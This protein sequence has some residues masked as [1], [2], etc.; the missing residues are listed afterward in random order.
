MIAYVAGI[1]LT[2]PPAPVT[3]ITWQ[4]DSGERLPYITVEHNGTQYVV[5]HVY[6]SRDLAEWAAVV[7]TTVQ[8]TRDWLNDL[9]EYRDLL[10]DRWDAAKTLIDKA[11]TA[12]AT[13]DPN[14][15]DQLCDW[16]RDDLHKI[17]DLADLVAP[18]DE[19]A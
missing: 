6:L 10:P 13:G 2:E 4:H 16:A 17:A 18:L 14:I 12:V 19:T 9:L 15:A 3:V 5:R 7:G 1:A 8:R 11:V